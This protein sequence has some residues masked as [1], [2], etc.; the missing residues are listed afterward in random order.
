MGS[1]LTV[2]L[3]GEAVLEEVV[4][5]GHFQTLE[6]SLLLPDPLVSLLPIAVSCSPSAVHHCLGATSLTMD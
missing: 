3:G 4:T 6:G 1:E 5:G 2:A